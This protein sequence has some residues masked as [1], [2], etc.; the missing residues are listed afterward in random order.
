MQTAIQIDVIETPALLVREIR[1]R[2]AR[3]FSTYMLRDDFQ[4][5]ISVRYSTAIDVQKF[6][7]RSV[8][9]QALPNRTSFHLAA[10]LK[11]CGTVVGDGFVLLHRPKSAELGW[12]V[13]PDLWGRGFG[14]EIGAVLAAIAFERLKCDSVWAKSFSKNEASIKLMERIGMQRDRVVTNREVTRG[15]HTDVIYYSMKSDDYFDASY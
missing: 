5:T 7:A 14:T 10:E 1:P 2:D 6:V 8:R 4:Q 12:S 13:H 11:A 3:A 9:R 15:E